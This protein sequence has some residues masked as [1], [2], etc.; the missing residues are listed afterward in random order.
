MNKLYIGVKT[1]RCFIDVENN[2]SIFTEDEVRKMAIEYG[3]NE[4]TRN[5]RAY[6]SGEL[7]L[8]GQLD[9][10]KNGLY[11]DIDSVVSNLESYNVYLL[12]LK[13][14]NSVIDMFVDDIKG[15]DNIDY[16]ESRL[17]MIHDVK[18]FDIVGKKN[19]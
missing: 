8:V 14:I 15:S 16:I 2:N 4:I 9:I 6:S 17:K 1:T 10:I 18:C 5:S 7:D 12:E 11:G 3:A 19:D 13:D